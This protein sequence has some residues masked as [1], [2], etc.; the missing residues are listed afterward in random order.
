MCI[1]LIIAMTHAAEC[2]SVGVTAVPFVYKA[3]CL[4]RLPSRRWISVYA[5]LVNCVPLRSL[6]GQSSWKTT[7][8]N[9]FVSEFTEYKMP[10]SWW[11]C[12]HDS[13]ESTIIAV[14][15]WLHWHGLNSYP[16]L[17]WCVWFIQIEGNHEPHE[18]GRYFSVIPSIYAYVFGLYVYTC[19]CMYVCAY[20]RT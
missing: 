19:T 12:T 9:S 8:K 5:I 7:L 15:R 17:Y 2:S 3:A 10:A 1:A 11:V 14:I 6:H 18:Y 4:F 20:V 13:D 16:L